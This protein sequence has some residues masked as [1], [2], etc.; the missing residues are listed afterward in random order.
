MT[1]FSVDDAIQIGARAL[2]GLI[3]AI[4]VLIKAGKSPE[5][6]ETIVQRNITSLRAIYEAEKAEDMAALDDKHSGG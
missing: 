4:E 6:A 5:E 2:P 3:E 1:D